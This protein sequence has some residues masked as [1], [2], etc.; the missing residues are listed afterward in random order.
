MFL[1]WLLNDERG[2]FSFEKFCIR[3]LQV[4]L[5]LMIVGFFSERTKGADPTFAVENKCPVA[6]VV[7]NLCPAAPA[8]AAKPVKY[9]N[10]LNCGAGFCGANGG[11]GCPSCPNGNGTC[12][13]GAKAAV[14]KDSLTTQPAPAVTFALPQSQSSCPPGGCPGTSQQSFGWQPFGGRFRK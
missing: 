8:K 10:G 3:M 9:T 14:A 1:N 7:T 6:F 2:Q 5:A 13:C 11:S 4:G 12:A